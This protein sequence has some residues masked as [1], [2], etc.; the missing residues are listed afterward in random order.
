MLAYIFS[1]MSQLFL[2]PIKSASGTM[3]PSNGYV[4]EDNST[5]YVAEDGSTY[6]VQE[7]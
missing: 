7:S 6:Y 3:T 5:Y 4:A 1:V 2:C